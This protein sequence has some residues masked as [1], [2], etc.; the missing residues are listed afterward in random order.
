MGDLFHKRKALVIR[1]NTDAI[2]AGI[3]G[4]MDANHHIASG[5]GLLQRGGVDGLSYGFYDGAD[6]NNLR[7]IREGMEE[8]GAVLRK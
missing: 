5:G 7:A 4:G 2:H 3:E 6:F 8:V 1:H